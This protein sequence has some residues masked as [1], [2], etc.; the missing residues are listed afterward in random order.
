MGL[1]GKL[2]HQI[3]LLDVNLMLELDAKLFAKLLLNYLL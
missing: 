1:Q 3:F 2:K